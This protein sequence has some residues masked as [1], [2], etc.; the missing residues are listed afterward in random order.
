MPT[1][2]GLHGPPSP[3]LPRKGGGSV[4]RLSAALAPFGLILRG[5]F[6][7]PPGETGLENAATVL[8]VGNAGG[9]M[10]EAFA[11]SIDGEPHPLDRWTRAVIEPI[12]ARFSAEAVFPFGPGAPPFQRWAE[13]AETL[14]R[15]PLGILIHPEYGLWHA[16][17]AALLFRERLELPPRPHAPSPCESCSEK[18]CLSAC[19]VAAFGAAGYDVPACAAH[20]ASEPADCRSV[21][22]HARG[23]CPA[24]PAWR[25]PDAQIR[26]HMAAFAHSV[27]PRPD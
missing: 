6:H 23:A 2:G 11:P 13:R 12:A 5:G 4:E 16:W 22:C 25:Y 20:L 18:P 10:W 15:S 7:P 8:L 26:F 27:A 1:A 19:P 24:G 9:A 17:R 21:G 14:Y 3:A